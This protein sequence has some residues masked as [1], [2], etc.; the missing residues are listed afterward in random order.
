MGDG[1]C[2]GSYNCILCMKTIFKTRVTGLQ[3]T[4]TRRARKSFTLN[5]NPDSHWSAALYKGLNWL[6][7]TGG[8]NILNT[9]LWA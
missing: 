9:R 6:Q 5:Y 4:T 7:F 3:K 8:T 1:H 2:S